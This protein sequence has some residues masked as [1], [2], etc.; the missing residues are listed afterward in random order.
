MEIGAIGPAMPSSAMSPMSMNTAKIAPTDTQG[1][2]T[3]QKV[4]SVSISSIGQQC[5]DMEELV[6]LI[7]LAL[8]MKD[9]KKDDESSLC[10]ALGITAMMLNKVAEQSPC[11]SIS[12]DD[13]SK[14]YGIPASALE[15]VGSA[16]QS[17]N[18]G[19]L[20]TGG[21]VGLVNAV[22]TV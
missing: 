19:S 5:C 7:L 12:F 6:K 17:G 8:L 2:T 9:D 18:L 16:M 4:D 13:G 1:I 15:Q 21:M 10:A 22:G 20:F 11:I 3:A 14:I